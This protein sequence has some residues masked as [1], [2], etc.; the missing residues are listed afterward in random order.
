MS[1]NVAGLID[2]TNTAVADKPKEKAMTETKPEAKPEQPKRSRKASVKPNV[3]STI[4]SDEREALRAE[5][6]KELEAELAGKDAGLAKLQGFDGE[7]ARA[8]VGNKEAVVV[9]SEFD[10]KPLITIGSVW[11]SKDGEPH[12]NYGRKSYLSIR[13]E[14]LTALAESGLL[15]K[16]IKAAKE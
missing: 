9:K 2:L 10:G 7:V 5:L 4:T 16:A 8:Q 13:P 14:T 15:D 1:L 12:Y 6:R 3:A 11:E